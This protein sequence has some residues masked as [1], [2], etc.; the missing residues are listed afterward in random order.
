MATSAN[1]SK[2]AKFVPAE[3]SR[4]KLTFSKHII[5]PAKAKKSTVKIIMSP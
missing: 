3:I 2:I 1:E 4:A 5:P